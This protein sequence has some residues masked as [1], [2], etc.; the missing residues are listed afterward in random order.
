MMKH[1]L[2]KGL[3]VGIIC[4]MMLV[5]IPIAHGTTDHFEDSVV[6][7]SGKCNTVE[8]TGLWLFGFKFFYDRDVTIQAKN[9]E[10]ERISC[11][12][13]NGIPAFVFYGF[14]NSIKIELKHATGLF[15]WGGK[16]LLFNNTPPRIL[17]RCKAQDIWITN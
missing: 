8:H 16:S 9:E 7:I 6:V 2:R 12:I 4:L 11:L 5:T 3:A 14:K 17:V 13:H 10:G 1:K 15:F